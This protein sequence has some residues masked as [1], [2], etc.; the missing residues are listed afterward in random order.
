MW[1]S[2]HSYPLSSYEVNSVTTTKHQMYFF[3]Y[4]IGKGCVNALDPDDYDS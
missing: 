3:E 4:S 2:K 1:F